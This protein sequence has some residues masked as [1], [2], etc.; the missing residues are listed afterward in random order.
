MLPARILLMVLAVL[1]FVGP[2]WGAPVEWVVENGGNGHFYEIVSPSGGITWTDARV[3][4]ESSS[5][6]GT[7]GHLVTVTSQAEWDFVHGTFQEGYTWIGL[8][9]EEQE[10]VFK[11]VTPEPF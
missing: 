10:G 11:W 2:V 1:A 4:A 5:Y 3:E 9:D 8:T 7:P 6:L